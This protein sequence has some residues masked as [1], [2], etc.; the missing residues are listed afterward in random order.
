[1]G[2]SGFSIVLRVLVALGTSLFAT[3]LLMGLVDGLG[4]GIPVVRLPSMLIMPVPFL[5][6][7]ITFL[8][9]LRMPG[10]EAVPENLIRWTV[11]FGLAGFAGFLG[12][13]GLGFLGTT[14]YRW[15]T[16]RPPADGLA[17]CV[18]A[19]VFAAIFGSVLFFSRERRHKKHMLGPHT[20]ANLRALQG[21]R[22]RSPAIDSHVRF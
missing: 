16:G 13:M 7:A 11:R 2:K 10:D 15:T 18:M 1:M 9:V 20:A 14:L 12:A 5:L 22:T 21:Q 17:F 8:M 4:Q 19:G 3:T 6:F